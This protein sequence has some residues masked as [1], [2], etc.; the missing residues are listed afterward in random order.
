MVRLPGPAWACLAREQA[1]IWAGEGQRSH[2][3]G[4]LLGEEQIPY[5]HPDQPLEM[6]LRYVDRWP[7]IPV[8]NRANVRK[9]EG[10]ISERDVLD[11]YRDLEGA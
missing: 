9:L 2:A 10:I 1:Q 5:V 8:V 11:R 7:V 3:L 6:V 4:T